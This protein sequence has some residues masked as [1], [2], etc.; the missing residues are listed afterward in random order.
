MDLR[1]KLEQYLDDAV[2]TGIDMLFLGELANFSKLEIEII[3]EYKVKVVNDCIYLLVPSRPHQRMLALVTATFTQKANT[4]IKV[5]PL[6][7]FS[8]TIFWKIFMWGCQS[9][10]A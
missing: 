6:V 5:F 8:W 2:A 10:A 4:P 7:D 1:Q 3:Y 9:K